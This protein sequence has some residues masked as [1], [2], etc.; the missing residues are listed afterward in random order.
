MNTQYKDTQHNDNQHNNKNLTLGKTLIVVIPNVM[1]PLTKFCYILN[2]LLL[3]FDET[4]PRT[5]ESPSDFQHGAITYLFGCPRKPGVHVI[6]LLL[7]SSSLT[8]RQNKL[9]CLS[10]ANIFSLV[11]KA[12]AYPS[13][14]MFRYSSLGQYPG[15][16]F[17]ILYFHCNLRM[18]PIS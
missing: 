2:D 10:L 18:G 13:G 12:R 14:A 1:A 11:R 15:P 7:S 4:F 3:L 6:K 9:E 17:T 8:K 5:A 16:I